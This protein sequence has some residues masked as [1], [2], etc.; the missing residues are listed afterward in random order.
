MGYPSRDRFKAPFGKYV[1]NIFF[2]FCV[3]SSRA[4]AFYWILFLNCDGS[5]G[6]FS[7]FPPILVPARTPSESPLQGE[8]C[9]APLPTRRQLSRLVSALSLGI[10][11]NADTLQLHLVCFSAVCVCRS[12]ASA[13]HWV[14]V[15]N[16]NGSLGFSPC[17]HLFRF[18]L[19]H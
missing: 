7:L 18:A 3:C 8:P 9:T 1:I 4:S 13:F 17:F 12:R 15:V 11:L 2:L 5:L 14:F 10:Q 19:R 6:F 16:R